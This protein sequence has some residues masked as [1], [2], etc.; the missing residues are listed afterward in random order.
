MWGT[1]VKG[2]ILFRKR[3]TPLSAR[4]AE[5]DAAHYAAAFHTPIFFP[6]KE[7]FGPTLWDRK[8]KEVF[9]F[10]KEI[11]PCPRVAR[12]EMQRVTL[13]HFTPPI[14]FPEKENGRCDRPKERRFPLQASSSKGCNACR[15]HFPARGAAAF[16]VARR[17]ASAP[18]IRYRSAHL[19]EV[20]TNFRLHQS[21]QCGERS[22][23]A[24]GR[25]SA[26]G[27]MSLAPHGSKARLQPVTSSRDSWRS[28]V[29][30]TRL[31]SACSP[32]S[33][34]F[35]MSGGEGGSPRPS[36]GD[37]KGVFSSRREYP[38]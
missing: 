4:R 33:C 24:F 8:S 17:F 28:H 18:I 20:R 25:Q 6:E 21:H 2:G 3:D 30:R 32:S 13:L 23:A 7:S 26:A 10:A 14:F 15:L 31:R 16:S 22:N 5:G 29:H 9:S 27:E 34:K 35:T 12:R 36:L 37:T 38:L 1:E 19:V 11:L